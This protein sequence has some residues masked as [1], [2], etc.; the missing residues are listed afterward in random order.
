[1]QLLSYLYIVSASFS[2][3]AALPHITCRGQSGKLAYL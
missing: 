2:D 1:M 3:Q